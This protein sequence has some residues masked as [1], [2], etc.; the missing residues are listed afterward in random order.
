MLSTA[1]SYPPA[2]QSN[3]SASP[4]SG[5]RWICLRPFLPTTNP[6]ARKGLQIDQFPATI[7]DAIALVRALGERYLWVDAICIVQD[8]RDSKMQDIERMDLIYSRA[9][10]TL[11]ALA[12]TDAAA[13]LP[14]VRAKTRRPQQVETLILDAGSEDLD[15]TLE[16]D[17]GS[18]T[19]PA[20]EKVTLRFVA[21][22]P[23]LHLTLQTSR[24]H[25]RGGRFKSAYSLG[26]VYTSQTGVSTF[27]AAYGASRSSPKTASTARF[28]PR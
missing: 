4:M 16:A 28:D 9:F 11:V 13:G 15:L 3:I 5:V 6:D 1:V 8:D 26:A 25:S 20:R 18:S 27:N 22:P 2:Q 17:V 7:A 10:A 24:W 12:G 19:G 23:P 14:G 21:A